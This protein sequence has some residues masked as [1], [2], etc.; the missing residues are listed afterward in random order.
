MCYNVIAIGVLHNIFIRCNRMLCVMFFHIFGSKMLLS[1]QMNGICLDIELLNLTIAK[2]KRK[3]QFQIKWLK[4]E[5]IEFFN[6]YAECIWV[7]VPTWNLFQFIVLKCALLNTELEN[8]FIFTNWEV[9]KVHPTCV[10]YHKYK[11]W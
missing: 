1:T 10:W 4:W 5:H 2:K 11:F 9:F 8:L 3:I 7:S 6:F